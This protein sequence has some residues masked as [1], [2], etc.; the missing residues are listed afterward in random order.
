M[1]LST[2]KSVHDSFLVMS[3]VHGSG[4]TPSCGSVNDEPSAS[5]RLRVIVV[6]DERRV[7][8]S[9]KD[10][11]LDSGHAAVAAYDGVSAVNIAKESCPDVL[12]CDVLMPNMNG[13]DTA[14]AIH[15]I[16]P[17]ARIVLFSGHASVS[18]ILNRARDEGHH[19][20]F[21]PKPIRPGDLLDKLT[22]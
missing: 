16:C 10:I 3:C 21:L 7:A 18:D 5:R 8:D 22:H 13:V 12:L 20:E 1:L 19:F 11:L 15:D 4:S 6:D 14:V 17:D 2:T 9:V